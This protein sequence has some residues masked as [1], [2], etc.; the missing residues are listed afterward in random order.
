MKRRWHI[1]LLVAVCFSA[2]AISAT[3]YDTLAEPGRTS[4]RGSLYEGLAEQLELTAVQQARLDEIVEEARHRMVALSRETKPRYRAIKRETRDRI[5]EI[6]DAE[7]LA[8][9]NAI[10]DTCDRRKRNR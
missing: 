4:R 6:L 9:F 1:G 8:T 2:G 3:V 5:R 7:Q 10:C